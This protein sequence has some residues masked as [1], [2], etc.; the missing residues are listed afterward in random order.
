M[1]RH[2]YAYIGHEE[3]WDPRFARTIKERPD[4]GLCVRYLDWLIKMD[5]PKPDE[6]A[7]VRRSMSSEHPAIMESH[8]EMLACCKRVEALSINFRID[9]PLS[10]TLCP[11]ILASIMVPFDL[12]PT[13]NQ[14]AKLT[15]PRLVN[16]IFDDQIELYQRHDNGGGAAW[17][18]VLSTQPWPFLDWMRSGSP[19]A[20]LYLGR[21]KLQALSSSSSLGWPGLEVLEIVFPRD[22]GD[23]S[24]RDF[25]HY[26][27]SLGDLVNLT[28]NFEE[29]C[30]DLAAAFWLA[31]A[32]QPMIHLKELDLLGIRTSP[33]EHA[34]FSTM[35]PAVEHFA[36]V[37]A[38]GEENP[39]VEDAMNRLF[40]FSERCPELRM[41]SLRIPGTGPG[42]DSWITTSPPLRALLS[43]FQSSARFPSLTFCSFDAYFCNKLE[44]L[45]EMLH[46]PPSA[47]V[48]DIEMR[49]EAVYKGLLQ[50]FQ[51]LIATAPLELVN[52]FE[53]SFKD[54]NENSLRSLRACGPED[55]EETRWKG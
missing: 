11:S 41:I 48:E 33:A 42:Y 28:V 23:D 30:A 37:T 29:E 51:Q 31:F 3:F 27:H 15:F 4:Y 24:R 10:W 2:L 35:F 50:D 17:H 19:I 46:I 1:L 16:L 47:S 12:L 18:P 13:P 34:P 52:L 22:Q 32:N 14:L 8:I 38:V 9:V 25:G 44:E 21:F 36:I 45:E 7:I 5:L 20:S 53:C 49:Y 39:Q 43:V 55:I 54:R 6:D 26:V 40:P